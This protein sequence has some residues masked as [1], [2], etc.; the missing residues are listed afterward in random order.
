L[1]LRR[2]LVRE[3][4]DRYPGCISSHP[5]HHTVDTARARAQHANY[6]ETLSGL[7]LEV[8]HVP[9][10]DVHPDS[11]FVEDNAVIHGGRALIC[12][13]AK[14]SR[15]GEQPGVEAVLREYMSVKRATAPATV[16]G[17]D[18]VHLPDRLI[19]GVTQR[20]N[21]EGVAQMREWL[22][23]DVDTV[24]DPDIIH[25]KSYFTSL[26][27]GKVIV[28]RKY[29][30]HPALEGLE[31]LIVPE[32]EEY[33]ADTLTVGDTVIIPEGNHRT[34]DMLRE[35]GYE[36]ITLDVSEFEKCEGALTCLSIL[37]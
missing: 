2:A 32:E 9:R 26:G 11:C 15:R 5:L 22:R 14:E 30:D 29:A 21:L 8:I 33:A 35:A 6:C 1:R 24:V 17:G 28:T 3:P 25:L 16:E 7:G 10:D 23:V 12:R 13:M 31:T 34:R 20:T 37:C 19:S 27:R 18:V 4:G 36:V